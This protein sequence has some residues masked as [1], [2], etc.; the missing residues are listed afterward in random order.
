MNNKQLGIKDLEKII[1][2]MNQI[3]E[4]VSERLEQLG[5]MENDFFEKIKTEY[6][7]QIRH[8]D[9]IYNKVDRGAVTGD[10][11]VFTHIANGF[12]SHAGTQLNKCYEVI[13]GLTYVNDFGGEQLINGLLEGTEYI[14]YEEVKEKTANEQRAEIIEK[15]KDFIDI[16]KT[17]QITGR[18]QNGVG[19]PREGQRISYYDAYVF[20]GDI[21]N[22]CDVEF[23][24]NQEK[25]TVVALMR[26][27]ATKKVYSKGIAKC[28][29][30]DVFNAHIG[31]A[32]ALGRAL[33]KDVSEF[34]NAVRPTVAVGQTIEVCDRNNEPKGEWYMVVDGI[35]SRGYPTHD[36]GTITS[37]YLI[38][39]DTNAVYGGIE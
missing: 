21:K 32:I 18:V 10:V 7:S 38:I 5:R 3:S 13:R 11:V 2:S 6:P 39:D 26:G 30:D 20:G 36:D 22:V 31:K 1:E 17:K 19:L 37:V 25:R 9:K 15:A 24:I 12:I 4:T 23:I 29:P 28:N 27:V 8:N 14:V 33:G 34:E 35:N 16:T